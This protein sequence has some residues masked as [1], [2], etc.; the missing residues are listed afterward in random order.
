[1][2]KQEIEAA[3]I[4]ARH[5]VD[6]FTAKLYARGMTE[7]DIEDGSPEA[8]QYDAVYAREAELNEL[9]AGSVL[10]FCH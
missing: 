10:N 2:T 6:A 1:M 8:A 7:A 3:L 4:D 9:K 5:A